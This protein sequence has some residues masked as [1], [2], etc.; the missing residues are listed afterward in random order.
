MSG[1]NGTDGFTPTY[2]SC[3]KVTDLCPVESTAYGTQLNK[4]AAQ[5]FMIIFIVCIVYQAIAAFLLRKWSFIIWLF[6]G[7]ALE[8]SGYRQRVQLAENAWNLDAFSGQMLALLLGPTLVA[9]ALSV[10]FKYVV[11]FYGT[12]HSVLR[13]SLYP[14]IF[15]GTDV[16]SIA[17]QVTGGALTAVATS[18]STNSNLGDIGEKLVIAG[19]SFQVG[20]MFLCGGFMVSYFLRRRAAIRKEKW[21]GRRLSLQD[22]HQVTGLI[23]GKK[24]VQKA[25]IFT[26]ALAIGYFC[27]IIRTCYR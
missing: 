19:V 5:A 10:T 9:A 1:L 6:L 4:T 23:R 21:L 27:I 22:S 24:E 12:V 8:V 2:D 3:D 16:I 17:I 14:W 18:A 15:V 25:R 13:P 26:W 7:T 11:I 20:N